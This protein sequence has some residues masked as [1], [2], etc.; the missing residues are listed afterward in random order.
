MKFHEFKTGSGKKILAGKS[1]EQN[2]NL[3]SQFIGKSNF[4]FHTAKPGSPFCVILEKPNKKDLKETAIFCASKSH[5]W[6]DNKKDVIVHVFNGKDIYK[7]K[8]MKIGTFGV[9]KFKII[10]IKKEEIERFL[11]DES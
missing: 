7:E 1:A 11:K 2:E 10:K 5:D 4:I 8:K 9:K 6:R 3:T